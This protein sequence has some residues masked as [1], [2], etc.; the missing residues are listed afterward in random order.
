MRA[1]PI[2]Y[3]RGQGP[4]GNR[5]AALLVRPEA[6]AAPEV[7]LEGQAPIRPRLIASLFGAGIWRYEFSVPEDAPAA[8]AV[9]SE[10][11]EI[12][13]V[14][15]PAMRIAY[16][17]CNGQEE[18]DLDRDVS[19]RDVMWSRLAREHEDHPFALL[20]QGGDQLYADDV[21]R[22]HPDVEA[23]AA[24]PMARRGE[25]GLTDEMTEAIRR[26]YFF[27]YLVTFSRPA[28]AALSARVPSVMMWDDH[29]IVDGWGSHPASMLDSAVG[30]ALF[31]AAREMFLL[32]QLAALEGDLPDIA[33]D[34]RGRTLGFAL[35]YRGL[36]LIVPDL[37]SE[38]RPDRV[39]DAPGWDGFVGAVAE[40]PPGDRVLVLS[41]VP[42]LGPRLSLVEAT[43]DVVPH[44]SGFEDDLRDQW[45]S[46]VHRDEWRRF[47]EAL[48]ER[49]GSEAGGGVTVLSGE[50][51]L[52]TRGEMRLS[53]GATIHQLVASGISHPAPLGT[54]PILLGLLARLGESPVEG[55]KIRILPLPGSRSTYCAER[56]YLVL[57]REDEAWTAVWELEKSLRTSK[58]P[59]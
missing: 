39:M 59:I 44:R 55:T 51:H 10:R 42:A 38:R 22:C 27:R 3:A 43:L 16:V 15:A 2:L 50:I 12:Q 36:S 48:A 40:T 21:L 47:L 37:R 23:W 7:R 45:Q 29:D 56:N 11:Y 28:F 34:P 9:D 6:E 24:L 46:R 30:R 41:S 13:P 8:Y 33:F 58:L 17:S 19:E 53:G 54:Y 1:G 14:D 26:F 32:F 5:V 18:G 20:L 35:R 52:A 57:A 25:I 31:V 49:A 4:D